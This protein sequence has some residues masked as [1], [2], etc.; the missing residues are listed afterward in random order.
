MKAVVPEAEF[1]RFLEAT[2]SKFGKNLKSTES[3]W[4]INSLNSKTVVSVARNTEFENRPGIET[5]S[6]VVS[7]SQCTLQGY[8]LDSK[9]MTLQ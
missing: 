6:F 8:R 2:L 9:D 5:F 7:D 1:L 3:D 4:N